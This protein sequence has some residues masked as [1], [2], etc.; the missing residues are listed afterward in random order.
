MRDAPPRPLLVT[1]MP[2][3]GTSWTGR[4][5][6]FSGRV[7][8]VNE[9]MNPG[10]PPGRSPGVL[11]ADVEHQFQYIADGLD[12]TFLPAFQ[13]TARLR[14][15]PVAELRRNSGPYD[16]ARM[17]KYAMAFGLGRRLGRRA[18]F[19]DPYAVL[20]T[21]WFAQR[22]GADVVV[23]IREP[24]AVVSSWLRFGWDMNFDELLHQPQLMADHLEPFRE[25]LEHSRDS[26]ALGR[27][28]L[29]WKVLYSVVQAMG[30]VTPQIRVIRH[31]DLAA[32]PLRGF[33]QL[34]AEL[35]LPLTDEGARSITRA[36]SG[37]DDGGRPLSWSFAGGL[38]SRTGFQRQD[39]R[40]AATSWRS[41]L[42]AEQMTRIRSITAPVRDSYYPTAPSTG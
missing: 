29:L 18:M 40:R 15:R 2:R 38:P 35:G 14:Y 20:C 41:R 1:G 6:E 33:G 30:A 5:L 39:S 32:D 27:V 17:V 12:A 7:V 22:L 25:D 9:P 34:Y 10:H 31:E 16:V 3:S 37:G 21:A 28:A 4:M 24:A 42:S 11:A 19:D 23:L 36:T 8:Y 13:D 26:D